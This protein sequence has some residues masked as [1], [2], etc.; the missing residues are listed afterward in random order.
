MMDLFVLLTP[1]LLL[2]VVALL[3]FVGC[4]Q[5]FGINPTILG[6]EVDSLIPDFGPSSGGT[7]VQIVGSNFTGA[8]VVT[9]GGVNA[10]QFNVVSDA[11]INATAPKNPAGQ[12]S[13]VVT[14]TAD[15]DTNLYPAYFTYAA[16]GFVQTA[17]NAQPINPPI[18]V[19]VNNTTPGNLLI[20]AVTYGGP[21]A[22]SVTVSDNLGNSFILAG[23][24]PWLRQ[25]RLFYLPNIPGGNMTITATGAGGAG[26]PCNI[27]VSE[28]S[29][30]DPSAQAV[31]G[32]STK[33]S[34][35]AGTPG[36]E[37]MRGIAVSPAQAGDVVYV[38]V[39]ASQPTS[40]VAGSGF[41]P[42]PSAT[43]LL[44][45]EDNASAVT[46]AQTVATDDTTGGNF[47]PWVVL[48]VAIKA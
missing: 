31:Y 38:V 23:S 24:G 27:S 13:V 21:P 32:F 28:Y 37:I 39:I 36:I 29:G 1:I 12:A 9:F 33:A 2:A 18:S 41:V 48:A 8:D 3:G 47:V 44:L 16:I 35:N 10:T 11:Q 45:V 26:G 40:L 15:N 20:A 30:A 5:V 6:I 25:S 14:R 43:T 46:A 42:H 4:N 7:P 34:L 19:A 17:S 22:G